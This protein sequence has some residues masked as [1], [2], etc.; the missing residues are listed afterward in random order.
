MNKNKKKVLFSV[1]AMLV[2][3]ALILFVFYLISQG[4]LRS[5][6]SKEQVTSEVDKL[7]EKD[8]ETKY[9]ETPTELIKYYWRLNKCIYNNSLSDKDMQKLLDQLRLLYDDELLALEENSREQMLQQ[10][11]EDKKKFSDK[12]Q[13]IATYIVQ[14]N[15]KVTYKTI[16]KRECATVLTGTLMKVKNKSQRTQTYE[17]FL[18]R[19]DNKGK[20]RILGWKQTTD[21]N[22]ISTLGD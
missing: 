12:N 13:V 3:A 19:K 1:T 4:K 7:L 5:Y 9:P 10:M 18:C 20:W 6:Q 22:E 2:A 11:Q 14:K 8:L 16:D 17:N 15:S 21:Q